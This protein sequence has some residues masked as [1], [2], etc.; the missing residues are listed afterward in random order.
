MLT[1]SELRRR[2]EAAPDCKIVS[3]EIYLQGLTGRQALDRWDEPSANLLGLV[4]RSNGKRIL[5]PA[6]EFLR[7]RPATPDAL[8]LDD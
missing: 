8:E 6:E 7:T 2:F 3:A 4:D 1:L 5:V